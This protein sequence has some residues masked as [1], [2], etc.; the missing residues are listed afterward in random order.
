LG[1]ISVLGTSQRTRDAWALAL[2]LGLPAFALGTLQR[3]CGAWAALG[4]P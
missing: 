4:E 2:V 1:Y 3:T